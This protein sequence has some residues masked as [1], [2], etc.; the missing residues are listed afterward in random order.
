MM[1]KKP[2]PRSYAGQPQVTP[3][4][5][6]ATVEDASATSQQKPPNELIKV[7]P[8]DDYPNGRG[9]MQMMPIVSAQQAAKTSVRPDVPIGPRPAATKMPEIP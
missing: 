8:M 2:M 6:R 3:M 1:P 7:G 9:G 4:P 5:T